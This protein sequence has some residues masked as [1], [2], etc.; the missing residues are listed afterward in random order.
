MEQIRFEC[1]WCHHTIRAKKKRAGTWIYCPSCGKK[2]KVPDTTED[3]A[4]E[5]ILKEAKKQHE[6]PRR[7][8]WITMH[9][10]RI[11]WGIIATATFFGVVYGLVKLISVLLTL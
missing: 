5:A 8:V 1:H 2:A 6:G 9:S 3:V 7:V 11:F 10:K 4:K